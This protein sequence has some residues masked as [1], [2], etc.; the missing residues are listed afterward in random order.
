[1]FSGIC[2][3]P[4]RDAEV[5]CGSGVLLAEEVDGVGDKGSLDATVA[6][7][8]T[9]LEMM[10]LLNYRHIIVSIVSTYGFKE[11]Y[12]INFNSTIYAAVDVVFCNI[13]TFNN[14]QKAAK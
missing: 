9:L 1:L 4:V 6:N 12:C 8:G 3:L 5:C 14:H 7:I 11:F 10:G 2:P 13:N